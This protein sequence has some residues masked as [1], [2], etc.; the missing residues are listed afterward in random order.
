MEVP[1]LTRPLKHSI[2]NKPSIFC[3]TLNT[4]SAFSLFQAPKL[5]S[6]EIETEF[7]L[8]TFSLSARCKKTGQSFPLMTRR[9]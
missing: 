8:S 6:Q 2:K 1:A 7:T 3:T 9:R 5:T 4:N